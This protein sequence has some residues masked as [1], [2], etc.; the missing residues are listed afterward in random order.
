MVFTG[1][2]LGP[3][4]RTVAAH[5][6]KGVLVESHTRQATYMVNGVAG[7]REDIERAIV[8]EVIVG[9]SPNCQLKDFWSSS[10][11]V[12]PWDSLSLQ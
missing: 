4:K 3:V 2:E 11:T 1:T 10:W 8:E 7:R 6:D 5:E 9:K 12:R